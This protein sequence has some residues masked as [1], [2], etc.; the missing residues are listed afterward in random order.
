MQDDKRVNQW[1]RRKKQEGCVTAD[2]VSANA[3]A[4][5]LSA[6]A[7][8]QAL[9][10]PSADD[11]PDAKVLDERMRHCPKGSVLSDN[12]VCISGD[13]IK[14][15]L[16][17]MRKSSA[18]P[19]GWKAAELADL[20]VSWHNKLATLSNAICS[21]KLVVPAAWTRVAVALIPKGEGDTDK[22]PI[23]VASVV[24]R[25]VAHCQLKRINLVD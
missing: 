15:R 1:I 2:A 4:N 3:E 5:L 9:W 18:G 20:P 25:A 11:I 22:R 16:G 19:D 7:K 14:E 12:D 6:A 10:N 13:S 8:F 17:H 23:T 24:W 21:S